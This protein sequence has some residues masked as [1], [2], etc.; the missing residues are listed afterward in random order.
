MFASWRPL[1]LPAFAFALALTLALALPGTAAQA[2]DAA[3]DRDALE[4]MEALLRDLGFDPGPVD[5]VVDAA[6]LAAIGRYHDF[7]LRPGEPEPSASLLDELRGVAAAF[8]ALSG[9]R[10]TS[11]E[12]AVSAI[13][14]T[15]GRPEAPDDEAVEEAAEPEEKR[16]VPPPPPPQKLTPPET[17]TADAPEAESPATELPEAEEEEIATA[18]PAAVEE[19]GPEVPLREVPPVE[20]AI[21]EAAVEEEPATEAAPPAAAVQEAAL[22][23]EPGAD[24]PEADAADDLQ[25]RVDAELAPYRGQLADGSLTREDLAWK[26]NDEGRGLLQQSHYEEAIVKFSAALQLNPNFAGAYSNRGT[27][28]QRLSEPERAIADFDKAKELGF[29]GFRVRDGRTPLN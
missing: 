28:Y 22:P 11:P 27:A 3:L 4:E 26:L 8:A 14:E 13:P 23:D 10:A 29:G 17:L 7:A 2:A 6:T 9:G 24:D 15:E 5:G 25:S 20:P 19:P 18:P 16:L 12:P 21:A 1:P